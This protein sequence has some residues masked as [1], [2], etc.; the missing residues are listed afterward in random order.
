MNLS[1]IPED[2]VFSERQHRTAVAPVLDVH[3]SRVDVVYFFLMIV[4]ACV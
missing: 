2:H 1:I 4:C 3:P